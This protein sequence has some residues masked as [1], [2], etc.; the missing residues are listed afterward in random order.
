MT[1]ANALLMG[2]GVPAAKFAHHGDTVGGTIVSEP[3]VQQQRDFVSGA[4]LFWD[5]GSPRNQIKVVLDTGTTDPSIPDDD[6][7]RAL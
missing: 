3:E 4:L 6:G 5:D 2:G 1:T 7:H